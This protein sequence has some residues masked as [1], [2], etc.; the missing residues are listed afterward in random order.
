M[1][2]VRAVRGGRAFAAALA[3]LTLAACETHLTVRPQALTGPF[4]GETEDGKPVVLTF[5]EEAQSFLGE[6]TIGGEPLVL[7]GAVGWRGVAS[8]QG[9]A[10]NAELVDLTL[11]ADGET[12][13]LARLGQPPLALQRGGAPAPALAPGPFSGRFRAAIGRAPLAEVTL[14]QRGSLL[15]GVGIVTEDPVGIAGRAT[16]PQTARGV[17][18]FLDGTQVDFDA[19]LSDGGATLAIEGFGKTVTLKR[20]SGP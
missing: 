1:S 14:V 5:R 18:T 17:V 7:A 15:S 6:G 10:G 3:L 19:E 13:V 9:A 4:S 2:P 16:G 11:S 20:R 12:L 8:L